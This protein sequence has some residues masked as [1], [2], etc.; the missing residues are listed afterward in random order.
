MRWSLRDF[1]NMSLRQIE[2]EISSIERTPM[3]DRSV[4]DT[5]LLRDLCAARRRIKTGSVC[6]YR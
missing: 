3:G 6:G 5:E 4:A 1:D 2:A